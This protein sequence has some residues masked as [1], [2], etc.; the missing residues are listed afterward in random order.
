MLPS[1]QKLS[2]ET[3]ITKTK[4]EVQNLSHFPKKK[5]DAAKIEQH[6][7]SSSDKKATELNLFL[8]MEP[9]W[10]NQTT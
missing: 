6:E 10:Q 2:N 7:I 9:V 5:F 4:Q 3:K 1:E 8:K